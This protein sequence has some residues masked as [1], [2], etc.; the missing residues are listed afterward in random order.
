MNHVIE[1]LIV[2][3]KKKQIYFHALVNTIN[4]GT[5][6]IAPNGLDLSFTLSKAQI[7][8]MA[9]IKPAVFIIA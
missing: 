3:R 5:E 1:K 2:I 9:I 7:T 4:W 6:G 8:Q